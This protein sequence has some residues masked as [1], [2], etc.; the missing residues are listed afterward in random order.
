MKLAVRG[1]RPRYGAGS[2]SDRDSARAR[3]SL[4]SLGSRAYK[5][6]WGFESHR[7]PR[8]GAT[9]ECQHSHHPSRLPSFQIG[10]GAS[11]ESCRGWEVCC[12]FTQ[13]FA[14]AARCLA[15][16]SGFQVALGGGLVEEGGS[17]QGLNQL[18]LPLLSG[19]LHLDPWGSLFTT[20][21]PSRPSAGTT[22]GLSCLTRKKMLKRLIRVHRHEV[23]LASFCLV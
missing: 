16:R 9:C 15:G 10:N 21:S 13:K 8:E 17:E 2:P 20:A 23:V 5:R 14:S 3:F 7:G 4:R 1:S 18:L 22:S 6:R 12:S 11:G 19:L